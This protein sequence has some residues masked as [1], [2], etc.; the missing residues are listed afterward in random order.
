MYI[1]LLRSNGACRLINVY[2]KKGVARSSSMLHLCMHFPACLSLCLFDLWPA[3]LSWN[4][5]SVRHTC[6]FALVTCLV[7]QK[8]KY[9]VFLQQEGTKGG[10]G[11]ILTAVNVLMSYGYS[12]PITYSL[13]G[14]ESF[15]KS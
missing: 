5:A 15:L 7:W 11:G 3:M 10:R 13:H 2:L 4:I 6:V 14:A 12:T 8:L 9:F 1:A